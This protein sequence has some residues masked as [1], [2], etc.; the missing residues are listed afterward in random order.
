M[1]GITLPC[2]SYNLIKLF[3]LDNQ[4]SG[5]APEIFRI[6]NLQN[7]LIFII[8]LQ[9]I[10]TCRMSGQDICTLGIQLNFFRCTN[11]NLSKVILI[12]ITILKHLLFLEETGICQN[13]LILQ[14]FL[15]S[16]NKPAVFSALSCSATVLAFASFSAVSTSLSVD[17]PVTAASSS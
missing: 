9:S 3:Y 11:I 1:A 17:R 14:F 12:D 13:I 8:F 15:C 6:R 7:E 16:E 2:H 4:V 10:R 5:Y